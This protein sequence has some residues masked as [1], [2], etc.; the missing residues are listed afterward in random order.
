MTLSIGN[1]NWKNLRTDQTLVSK[2]TTE[3]A[4]YVQGTIPAVHIIVVF[5]SIM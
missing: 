2:Q 3:G 1:G 4:S 5:L